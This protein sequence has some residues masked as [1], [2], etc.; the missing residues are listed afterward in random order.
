L[1]GKLTDLIA[2]CVPERPAL[3]KQVIQQLDS[4]S[5]SS[6]II[7]SNSSSYTCDELIRGL[8]LKHKSRILSAHTYWPPE[9]R[10]LKLTRRAAI[11]I[12]GHSET[13]VACIDLLMQKSQEHGFTPFKVKNN[14][15]G[16]LYNRIWAAIKREALLAAAEGAGTPQEIDNIFK[17]VLK[18]D[19]GPFEQMDVVGLDVVLDIE[20]HYAGAR[21][22]IPNEPQEYLA[23]IISEGR[24]GVKSG[25][26]FYKY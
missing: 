13:D 21:P 3:K 25:Q 14:S 18:T 9:T 12:M 20:K 17:D 2:K 4:L 22:G 23:K 10:E 15:M 26:G 16:Y 11:E 19:N 6:T 24:L 7:A 8:D 5:P 1:S